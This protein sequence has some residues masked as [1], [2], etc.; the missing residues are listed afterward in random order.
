MLGAYSRKQQLKN[1]A[2]MCYMA[3][4]EAAEDQE[5]QQ[6]AIVEY[7]LSDNQL[8]MHDLEYMHIDYYVVHIQADDLMCWLCKVRV[9]SAYD[10]TVGAWCKAASSSSCSSGVRE[11]TAAASAVH[12]TTYSPTAAA[13]VFR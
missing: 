9:A 3:I 4:T 10:A 11:L 5:L 2:S 7:G 8:L 6:G 12:A 1:G 13:G